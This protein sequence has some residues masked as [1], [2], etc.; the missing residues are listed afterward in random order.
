MS[1]DRKQLYL[2]SL[3]QYSHAG[4]QHIVQELASCDVE[5]AEV[6]YEAEWNLFK[7]SCLEKDAG[8]IIQAF[9][10]VEEN[11]ERELV[12]VDGIDQIFNPGLNGTICNDLSNDFISRMYQTPTTGD[13][14]LE[15]LD[16]FHCPAEFLH[17]AYTKAWTE[18]EYNSVTIHALVDDVLF[19]DLA[20]CAGVEMSYGTTGKVVYI[21]G[22]TLSLVDAAVQRLDTLLKQAVPAS[23][24][25]P[26]LHMQ[27][28]VRC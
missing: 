4:V 23:P 20:S 22:A 19:Q 1:T 8:T 10:R 21:G 18:L 3:W 7:V 16:R 2:G 24:S 27:S 5:M 9:K 12:E 15:D 13:H 17:F 25:S 11:V 28:L 14:T 26:S 6:L